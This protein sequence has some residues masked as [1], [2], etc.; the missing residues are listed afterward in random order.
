MEQILDYGILQNKYAEIN[1][2]AV[3][4]AMVK[5]SSAEITNKWCSVFKDSPCLALPCLALPSLPFSH[6]SR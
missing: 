2:Q 1:K 3:L 6:F 5:S 4:Q